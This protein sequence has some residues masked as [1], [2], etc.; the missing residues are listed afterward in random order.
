MS[1][2][3]LEEIEEI[4]EIVAVL[5]YIHH[6]V[7]LKKNQIGNFIVSLLIVALAV[8]FKLDKLIP[9]ISFHSLAPPIGK[10]R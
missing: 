7:I 5:Q 1:P 6:L 9:L 10:V 2:T 3:P 4:E 8:S